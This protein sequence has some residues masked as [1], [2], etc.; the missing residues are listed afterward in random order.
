[1]ECEGCTLCCKLLNV[2]WMDSPAGELCRECDE[3][4]G[5]KIYDK[6]PKDC[7]EFKCAYNQMEKASI[8]LRPDKCNVIFERINDVFIGTVDP[9]KNYFQ[10]VVE[11]QIN[12]FLNEGFS[13]IMFN[14]KESKPIIIPSDKHTKE[15]VWNMVQMEVSKFN[16]ST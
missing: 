4:K 1:M 7:L 9:D 8:N 14:I 6:A 3:G 2:D 10:D 15:E 11:G 13:I 12:S 5:C 16:G